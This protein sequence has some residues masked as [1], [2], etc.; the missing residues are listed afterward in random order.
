MFIFDGDCRFCRKWAAWLEQRVGAAVEFV[1]FQAV[2]DLAR[3]DLTVEDVQTASY[4]IDDGRA[5]RGAR[6]IARAMVH[7]RS[8]WRLVGMVLDLPGARLASAIAYRFIAGNR[9]RLPAPHRDVP[10]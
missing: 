4:L 1:P 6:G 9:H 7:G 10:V 8:G 5:Y 2:D 3:F